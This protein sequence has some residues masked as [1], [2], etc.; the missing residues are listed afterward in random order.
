MARKVVTPR[1][2]LAGAISTLIQKLIQETRTHMVE[3]M[4]KFIRKYL[5]R[6]PST[7]SA[8]SRVKVFESRIRSVVGFTCAA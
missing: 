1:V 8:F 7:N 6:R 2:T 5:I 4:Y 3:G